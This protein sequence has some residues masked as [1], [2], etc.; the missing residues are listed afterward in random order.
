MGNAEDAGV[1]AV[2]VATE[3]IQRAQS[4]AAGVVGFMLERRPGDY[5]FMKLDELMRCQYARGARA[6]TLHKRPVPGCPQGPVVYLGW[7]WI[8]ARRTYNHYMLDESFE[9]L[10]LGRKVNEP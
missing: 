6:W 8:E 4:S 9:A 10:Y 5:S 3:V 2:I 7:C 1:G